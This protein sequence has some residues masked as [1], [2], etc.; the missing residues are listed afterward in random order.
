MVNSSRRDRVLIGV[1]IVVPPLLLL[2]LRL[3][4]SLNLSSDNH[5]FH[6]YMVSFTSLV[7][8]VVALFVASGTGHRNPQTLFTEMAFT[9]TAGLFLIHGLTTPGVLLTTGTPGIGLSGRLSLT[10][11]AIFLFLATLKL[12]P[13]QEKWINQNVRN[14]W[15][16]LAILYASY[17]GMV[18]GLPTF[19]STLERSSALSIT[20]AIF[21]F[22]FLLWGARRV[23]QAQQHESGRLLLAL[24]L[25]L[26]WLAM[27]QVS[28]ITTLIWTIAWWLYHAFMLSA[29]IVT[30][31]SLIMDYENV[32]SFSIT[33]YFSALSVIVGIPIVVLL[34]EAVVQLSGST[35]SRWPMFAISFLSLSLLF[36][37][38]LLVVRRA[39]AILKERAAAL[40]AEKQWRADLTNLIV[41]DLKS[42]LS[43]ISVSLGLVLSGKLESVPEPQRLP[44]ERAERSSLE[45]AQLIDNLL[46]VERFE[47]G[48]LQITPAPVALGALLQQTIES[49][50]SVAEAYD[51]HLDVSIPDNLPTLQI[52][53]ALIRRVL[54]NLI[55]N[56]IK[57]TPQNGKIRVSADR[58]T[59][60]VCIG[61]EDT[62]PGIPIDQRARIFDKFAQAAGTTQ[63]GA[64]LGLTFCR[65]AVEAHGGRIW[66]EDGTDGIGSRFTFNLPVRLM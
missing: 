21:T 33:R 41:H 17:I 59:E 32:L 45:M 24:T 35:A 3:F 47:A 7:A 46:D 31:A 5:F 4:P 57:F 38:L 30:M 12:R 63:H 36:L 53:A 37:V 52:D 42:P 19:V 2:A 43:V 34:S 16:V 1:L 58:T 65:L 64:G 51:L 13:G 61:I 14:L 56:A 55:T 22:V 29:F 9:S 28:Q 62:G 50:R 27:A 10:T 26:P 8:L 54:Q 40:E 60:S 39:E 20:L 66:M 6:F 49:V 15:L 18:F 48:A 44:L 23:W 25:A 11:G